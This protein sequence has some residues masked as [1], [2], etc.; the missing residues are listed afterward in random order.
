M[1]FAGSSRRSER[2][3]TR[4]NAGISI[5]TGRFGRTDEK[6]AHFPIHSLQSGMMSTALILAIWD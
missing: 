1:S 4:M 6:A 5:S 2:K 3:A